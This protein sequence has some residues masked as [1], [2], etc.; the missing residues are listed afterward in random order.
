M[1]LN[2]L[3]LTNFTCALNINSA[4]WI[5]FAG[6]S[7]FSQS[8]RALEVRVFHLSYGSNIFVLYIPAGTQRNFYFVAAILS[9]FY[10]NI[11]QR[12]AVGE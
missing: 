6:V 10:I 12:L 8:V 2:F 9:V 1:L 11:Q 5:S 4:T 7:S 3:N